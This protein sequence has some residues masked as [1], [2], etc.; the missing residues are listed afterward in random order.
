MS[1]KPYKELKAA[2]DGV[3]GKIRGLRASSTRARKRK[4]ELKEEL[5]DDWLKGVDPELKEFISV[6]FKET[7]Y[8]DLADDLQAIIKGEDTFEEE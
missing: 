6:I 8:G 5:G 1:A 3:K 4:E 2:Y 7:I